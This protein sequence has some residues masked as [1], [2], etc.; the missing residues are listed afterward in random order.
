MRANYLQRLLRLLLLL[1]LICTQIGRSA[2]HE[3]A[4]SAFTSNSVVILRQ[5]LAHL[6]ECLEQIAVFV[7]SFEFFCCSLPERLVE[8]F[9]QLNKLLLLE[10]LAH[11][12]V[13]RGCHEGV[14]RR[15]FEKT[16]R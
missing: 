7:L 15:E 5:H 13:H 8:P 14:L 1:F 10:T 3:H 11:Y 4:N 16:M 9:S 2:E 6:L 12:K